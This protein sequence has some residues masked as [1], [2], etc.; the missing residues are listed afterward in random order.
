MDLLVWQ[1]GG[2]FGRG[3]GLEQSPFKSPFKHCVTLLV[4]SWE[5]MAIIWVKYFRVLGQLDVGGKKEVDG[6]DFCMQ[7]LIE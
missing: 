1:Q 4:I 7:F 2:C 5:D 3:W 6:L